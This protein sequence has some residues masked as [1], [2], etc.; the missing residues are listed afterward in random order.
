MFQNIQQEIFT[1]KF[2]Y[3]NILKLR[4]KQVLQIPSDDENILFIFSVLNTVESH[5]NSP[6]SAENHF[7]LRIF[8]E[9][10]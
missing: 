2:N 4:K 5:G 7:L 8:L 1:N 6:R 3:I 9:K 10:L